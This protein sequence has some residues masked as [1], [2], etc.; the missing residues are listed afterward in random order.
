[1]PGQ[2]L[3][4]QL[5]KLP[6]SES[7]QAWHLEAVVV[8]RKMELRSGSEGSEFSDHSDYGSEVSDRSTL[9][10][11]LERFTIEHQP[12]CTFKLRFK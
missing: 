9:A 2:P 12:E 4:V 8:A 11:I 6:L 1:L 5:L 10:E 3:R 7:D